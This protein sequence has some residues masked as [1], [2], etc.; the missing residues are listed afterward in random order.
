LLVGLVSLIGTV[1][2]DGSVGVAGCA[3]AR[4]GQMRTGVLGLVPVRKF[5]S[6]TLHT[7]GDVVTLLGFAQG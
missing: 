4:W 6:G 1:S 2:P 7:G 3:P 5:P